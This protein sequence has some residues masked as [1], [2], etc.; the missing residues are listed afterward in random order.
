MFWAPAMLSFGSTSEMVADR[1]GVRPRTAPRDAPFSSA[2]TGLF[3]K[4]DPWTYVAQTLT[5]KELRAALRH[6]RECLNQ[7]VDIIAFKDCFMSTLETAY[8]LKDA[9]T[10]LIASPD[11]VPVEGWP[12]DRMFEQLTR[13]TD[14]KL[15]A[16]ALVKE[17]EQYYKVD[18][19]RHGRTEVPFD[20]DAGVAVTKFL[21]L[22][23]AAGIDL[24]LP[25][26]RH[27]LHG[28]QKLERHE[29]D[30][31]TGYTRLAPRS[32]G[33]LN[34]VA[35]EGREMEAAVDEIDP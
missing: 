7:E 33:L 15:A 13:Q 2:L 1:F 11:I 27:Q 18:A 23:N 25:F 14:A 32:T 5:L 35:E 6:G 20:D 29:T 19:N 3:A 12:Y 26:A 34:G 4:A 17:L 30:V 28:Q 8:E 31:A 24:V 16:K 22:Q 10:Y 21:A 9:A